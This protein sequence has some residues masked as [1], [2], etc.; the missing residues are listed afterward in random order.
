MAEKCLILIKERGKGIFKAVPVDEKM[1]PCTLGDLLYNK[2]QAR[3]KVKNL[4]SRAFDVFIIV[5]VAGELDWVE[6]NKQ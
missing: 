3:K 2:E 6:R 4:C 1:V 5:P